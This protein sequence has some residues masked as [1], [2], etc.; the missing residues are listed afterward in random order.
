MTPTLETQRLWLYPLQLSDADQI[1]E[2]FPHWEVVRFLAGR[3]PWPYP[4]DGARTYCRDIALPAAQRGEEWHWTLRSQNNATQV[5][6]C[7]SLKKLRNQNRGFWIGLTWQGQGLMSEACEVVTDYW[8]DVLKFPVLRVVKAIDNTAS[9]RISA[10]QGMR[11]VA[12]EERE[13]VSGR[14]P[15]EIWEITAE[16]WHRRRNPR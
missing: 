3:V 16:E 5:I 10:S 15:A 2:V 8:F 13:F 14:F 6:G 12:I 4:A 11:V 9:R 7:I 1:Q